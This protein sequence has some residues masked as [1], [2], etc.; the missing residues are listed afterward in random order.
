MKAI[1]RRPPREIK[2]L[3]DMV[4]GSAFLYGDKPLYV[5]KDKETK[6]QVEFSYNRLRDEVEQFGTALS[7]LDLIGAHIAVVGE[8]SAKFTVTYLGTVNTNSVI[9]PLDKEVSIEQMVGFLNLAEC[10][11]IVYSSDF[12]GK[13]TAL[14]EQ[15]PKLRFFVPMNGEDSVDSSLPHQPVVMPWEDI[16]KLGKQGLENRDLSYSSR[17][18]DKEKMCAILFTSGTTGTSKGVMLCMKNLVTAAWA[19]CLT[20]PYDDTTR[21]VSV[22]PQHHTYEMTCGHL[23]VINLGATAYINESLKY[24]MRNFANFK[25]NALVLVPL[26]VE[27]IYKRIWDEIRK[28]GK[29][30]AVRTLMKVS[31]ALL[32]IGIDLRAK[33]FGQILGALGGEVKTMICGGAPISPQILKDFYSFGIT[34]YEGYGITECAPLLACNPPEVIP[35]RF[36]SAGKPVFGVDV[37]IEREDPRDETGEIV[38]KGDNVMLGYYKNDKATRE[39][40]TP[41]EYYFRTGD[42][43]Y[44]DKDGYIFITGRKKNVIILSNGKNVFPEELEEHL[45][46]STLIKESVVVGRKDEASGEIAITALIFPDLD[47]FEGKSQ[48]EIDTAIKDEVNKINREL[49]SFKHMTAVEVRTEEFE[50]TTSKKIKRFLYQ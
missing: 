43:G 48:D 21:L 26:F 27:T 4:I 45:S 39:V 32:K 14:A 47:Q 22:L 1:K 11:M 41:R 19:S 9:V 44:I 15:M 28:K 40:F 42:I 13:L 25:P 36:G 5:Y 6:Q 24:V 35:P 18:I 16:L 17:V 2:D 31:D 3:R 38:A 46:H 23:A 30:K 8:T 37:K 34:I 10:Q 49:P 33:F 29:E 50:K 12:A 7:T 20:T